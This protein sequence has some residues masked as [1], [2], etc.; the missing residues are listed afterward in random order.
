MLKLQSTLGKIELSWGEIEGWKPEILEKLKL[1]PKQ[2]ILI[3]HSLSCIVFYLKDKSNEKQDTD[4]YIEKTTDL[5][6]K[7]SDTSTLN[8]MLDLGRF[9]FSRTKNAFC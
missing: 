3:N 6:F 2:S 9:M 8:S 7:L 4:A 1:N 5:L